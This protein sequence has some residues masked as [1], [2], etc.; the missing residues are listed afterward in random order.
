[1]ILEKGRFLLFMSVLQ[2]LLDIIS[3]TLSSAHWFHFSSSCF[4]LIWTG[5]TISLPGMLLDVPGT[6]AST[7]R[8]PSAD[9]EELICCKSTPCGNLNEVKRKFISNHNVF[10]SSIYIL[11]DNRLQSL[12]SIIAAESSLLIF[13]PSYK[14]YCAK[15]GIKLNRQTSFESTHTVQSATFFFFLPQH[16]IYSS[17]FS[18]VYEKLKV[19]LYFCTNMMIPKCLVE[20]TRRSGMPKTLS[21]QYL[22]NIWKSWL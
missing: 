19:K 1:M 3:A 15:K 10:V 16:I 8:T 20:H 4:C 11:G 7:D 22:N 13:S 12:K 18:W 21:T 17:F 2:R 6:G 9:S 5:M 14:L